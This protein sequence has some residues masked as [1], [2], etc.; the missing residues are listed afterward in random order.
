MTFH[1]EIWVGFLLST[2]GWIVL[3]WA[4]RISGFLLGGAVGILLADLASLA[5]PEFRANSIL[6]LVVILIF[7]FI[8][9][10]F[11]NKLFKIS[12]FVAGGIAA[13][14]LKAR[15][16]E[17]QGF[18]QSLAGGALGDFPLTIWFTLLC[19]LIGG[20]LLAL[21]KQ[22]VIV[23]VTALA[24][25]VLIAKYGGIEEKWLLLAMVGIAVQ[26]FCLSVLPRRWTRAA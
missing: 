18:S 14:L 20:G 10:V 5:F 25:A 8:G 3:P 7:G 24:G 1:P 26:V 4:V 2:M 15:L 16:D 23:A 17:F 9:A 12:F 6:L 13:I 22:Y 19:G 11:A 21:L